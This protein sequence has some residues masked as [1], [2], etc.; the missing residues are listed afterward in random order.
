MSNVVA[1]RG[2]DET[3]ETLFS[4][5]CNEYPG[6]VTAIVVVFDRDGGMHTHYRCNDQELAMAASRLLFLAGSGDV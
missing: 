5:I 2:K 3:L 4:R 6:V 1:L